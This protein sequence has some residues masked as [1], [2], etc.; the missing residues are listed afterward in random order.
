MLIRYD[1]LTTYDR[2]I[3]YL[4]G[5]ALIKMAR[6]IKIPLRDISRYL[7]RLLYASFRKGFLSRIQ[8][9]ATNIDILLLELGAPIRYPH[10]PAC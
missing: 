4:D 3:V 10:V 9:P 1:L 5:E 8:V 2:N 6:V 7:H